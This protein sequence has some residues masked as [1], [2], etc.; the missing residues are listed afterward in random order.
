MSTGDYVKNKAL[1]RKEKA[2]LT[3]LSIVDPY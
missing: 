1:R 2:S 3:A